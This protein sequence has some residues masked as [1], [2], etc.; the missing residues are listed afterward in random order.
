MVVPVTYPPPSPPPRG[1]KGAVNGGTC[2]TQSDRSDSATEYTWT[3]PSS[4]SGDVT[5]DA[6]CGHYSTMVAS[7]A[8]TTA[9]SGQVEATTTRTTVTATSATATTVTT[10]TTTTL[11]TA[12]VTTL[13]TRTTTTTTKTVTSRSTTT[14]TVT[15]TTITSTVTTATA[16]TTTVF[17]QANVDCVEEQD[18]C[19]QLCQPAAERNYNVITVSKARGKACVGPTDCVPGEDECPG[20][21]STKTTKTTETTTTTVTTTTVTTTSATTTTVTTI[22]ATATTATT[23]TASTTTTT[24]LPTLLTTFLGKQVDMTAFACRTEAEQ[25]VQFALGTND[26]LVCHPGGPVIWNLIKDREIMEVSL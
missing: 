22:T 3:A 21:T 17:N 25:D 6:L 10:A 23:I 4:D 20:I 24:T 26:P 12:T 5:I 11:T 8:E 15:T 19:T 7:A 13:T 1:K 2:S 9:F 18:P 14:K 16:T